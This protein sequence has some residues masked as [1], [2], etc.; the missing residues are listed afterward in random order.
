MQIT[1]ITDRELPDSLCHSLLQMVK[2]NSDLAIYSI[3][4]IPRLVIQWSLSNLQ[5]THIH[6][7]NFKNNQDITYPGRVFISVKEK[8]TNSCGKTFAAVEG[9]AILSGLVKNRGSIKTLKGPLEIMVNHG[10]NKKGVIASAQ[11]LILHDGTWKNGEGVLFGEEG[12]EGKIK[13]LHN[14]TEGKI[15]YLWKGPLR[16][17]LN[18]ICCT[19]GL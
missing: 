4:N 3:I 12:I 7:Q 13:G 16:S 8:F 18:M 15:Q 19:R 1:P 14:P 11:Q 6:E 5:F 9:L 17:R 2:S 10:N